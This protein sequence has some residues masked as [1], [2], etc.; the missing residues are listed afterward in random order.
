MSV[1]CSVR[2]WVGVTRA[3]AGGARGARRRPPLPVPLRPRGGGRAP[4]PR[5]AGVLQRH[6]DAHRH[7]PR[8][9]AGGVRGLGGARLAVRRTRAARP[10]GAASALRGAPGGCAFFRHGSGARRR[11]LSRPPGPT[12]GSHPHIPTFSFI[13]VSLSLYLYLYSNES[14]AFLRNRDLPDVKFAGEICRWNF[15]DERFH[16]ASRAHSVTRF[17]SEITS[18]RALI[19]TSTRSSYI[20]D[21]FNTYSRGDEYSSDGAAVS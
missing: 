2:A 1:R 10:R 7:Q 15:A 4:A 19:P 6:P 13:S 8:R 21:T 11:P 3:A 5:A 14:T 17:R 16:Q 9:A 18:G 12:P 20:E